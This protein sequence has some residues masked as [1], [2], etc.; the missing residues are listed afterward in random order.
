[1]IKECEYSANDLGEVAVLIFRGGILE[2]TNMNSPTMRQE[3]LTVIWEP[4][5]ALCS[6]TQEGW[7]FHLNF[8][9]KHFLENEN[10]NFKLTF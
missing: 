8:S 9:R 10:E 5:P 7:Q 3:L 2:A 1:M 4:V 6:K